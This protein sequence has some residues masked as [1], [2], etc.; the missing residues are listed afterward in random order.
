MEKIRLVEAYLADNQDALDLH[1]IHDLAAFPFKWNSAVMDHLYL[2]AK[3]S[4]GSY[5][6]YWSPDKLL[7]STSSE[8]IPLVWIDHEGVPLSVFAKSV[9]EFLALLYYDTGL[10]YEILIDM[11][12]FKDDPEGYENPQTKFTAK[13]L[14][15]YLKTL[16]E[17]NTPYSKKFRTWLKKNMGIQLFENPLAL[18]SETINH[19]PNFEQWVAFTNK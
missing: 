1:F 6:G 14:K 10:I 11:Y 2:F 16:D 4:T 19:Y 13:Y 18:I 3:T 9:D 8:E 5:I 17:G 15:K 7:D 12:F